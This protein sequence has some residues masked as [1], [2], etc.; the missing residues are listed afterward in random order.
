MTWSLNLRL[1]AYLRRGTRALES[2]AKSQQV[3]AEMMLN[4]WSRKVAK[5]KRAPIVW[6]EF[7]VVEANRRYQK[8]RELA[9]EDDDQ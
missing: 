4:E 1:I 6:G 5:P 3:I 7:D 2:I 9:G 8:E